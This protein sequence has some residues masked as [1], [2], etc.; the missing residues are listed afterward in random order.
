M[1]ESP[2][3]VSESLAR[4]FAAFRAGWFSR[5]HD[6][7]KPTDAER[8]ARADAYLRLLGSGIGSTVTFAVKAVE[9]LAKKG[10]VDGE[11]TAVFLRS[12]PEQPADRAWVTS[13]VG[14]R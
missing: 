11:A 2:S 8:A 9:K 3:P 13:D 7:L 10:A 6:Q 5:F 1:T 12:D 14:R 4:D